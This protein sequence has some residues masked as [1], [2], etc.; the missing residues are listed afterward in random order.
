MPVGRIFAVQHLD[1]GPRPLKQ[2]LVFR[3]GLLRRVAEIGQQSEV[4]VRIPIREMM[5]LQSLD[6]PID[7][8]QSW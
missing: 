2:R 1:S 3:Q 4:K 6:E 8:F 5:N 7:A